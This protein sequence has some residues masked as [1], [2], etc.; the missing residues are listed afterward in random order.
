MDNKKTIQWIVTATL[1]LVAGYVAVKFGKDAVDEQTW[2]SLGEGC[3]AVIIAALSIWTSVKARK[4][5]LATP[6]PP[7]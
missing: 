1:R 3:A 4:T 5:L 6:A 7:V 2:A